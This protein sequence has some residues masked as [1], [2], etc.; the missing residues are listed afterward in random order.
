MNHRQANKRAH[1][2]DP[3]APN[4]WDIDLDETTYPH[5]VHHLR[6]SSKFK[7]VPQWEKNLR[8]F[9]RFRWGAPVTE[10]TTGPRKLT[11]FLTWHNDEYTVRLDLFLDISISDL[12]TTTTYERQ[13]EMQLDEM[14][15]LLPSEIP[16]QSATAEDKKTLLSQYQLRRNLWAA[17][18]IYEKI[19]ANVIYLAMDRDE[20]SLFI[21][22]PKGLEMVYGQAMGQDIHNTIFTNVQ[23]YSSAIMPWRCPKDQR[24]G[25]TYSYWLERPQNVHL[26]EESD[27]CGVY[28]WGVWQELGWGR[29]GN[30]MSSDTLTGGS[31]KHLLTRKLLRTLEPLT[32]AVD[33]LFG[34]T[35]KSLRDEYKSVHAKIHPASTDFTRTTNNELF[36]LRVLIVNMLTEEHVDG[37][38]WTKGMAWLAVFGNFVGADTCLKKLGIRVPFPAGSI[39]GM[40]GAEI[41]HFTTLWEGPQAVNGERCVYVHTF[42]QKVK[43]LALKGF[44]P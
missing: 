9:L 24:H 23:E 21:Q 33:I 14:V 30:I 2:P 11:Q 42:H 29:G 38:D 28:H 17:N 25:L 40:M 16:S 43:E 1:P 41:P 20:H 26:K 12:S 22:F 32:W 5:P 39:Q 4:A 37:S 10:S 13:V 18:H 15:P 19:P 6:S 34:A 35:N 31:N 44:I 7:T 8:Q 36:A 27:R 3:N